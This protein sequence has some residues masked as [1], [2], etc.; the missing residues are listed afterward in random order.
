ML[1]IYDTKSNNFKACPN[2]SQVN[3]SAYTVKIK[4]NKEASYPIYILHKTIK[5]YIRIRTQNLF[6]YTVKIQIKK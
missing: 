6:L 1:R 5:L 3:P 2:Y 4:R